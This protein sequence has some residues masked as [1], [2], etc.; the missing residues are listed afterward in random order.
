MPEYRNLY[1]KTELDEFLRG[2]I[3]D[4]GNLRG[5][6]EAHR[7]RP[8]GNLDPLTQAMHAAGPIPAEKY[9]FRTLEANFRMKRPLVGRAFRVWTLPERL[10]Q[11]PGQRNWRP[12]ARLGK[13]ADGSWV[14]KAT[15]LTSTQPAAREA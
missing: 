1:T 15:T 12:G 13:D 5:L 11:I 8:G 4:P 2:P 10:V 3:S 7:W 14:R 6:P 9:A